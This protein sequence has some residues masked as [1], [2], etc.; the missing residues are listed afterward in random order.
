M[1]P[2]DFYFWKDFFSKEQ[3]ENIYAIK[4]EHSYEELGDKGAT[5]DNG[6][7]LKDVT[8]VN[9][10]E[11][12]YLIDNFKLLNEQ[13]QITNRKNYGFNIDEIFATD[14]VFFNE[15][16]KESRYDWHKDGSNHPLHDYKFTI[17]INSSLDNYEGGDFEIFTLGGVLKI[18][19]L[20]SF[21][22]VIMFNSSI[23]HRVTPV[24]EGQRRSIVYWRIGPNFV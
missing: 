3:V 10:V 7:N 6:Q 16:D 11:Y 22:S 8:K 21:G 23:I 20:N 24:T 14:A 2:Y 13:I 5:S 15:Y 9:S 19:Q 12:R 1:S 18:P 17:I 4:D